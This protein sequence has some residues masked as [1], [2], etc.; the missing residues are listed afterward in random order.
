M[1]EEKKTDDIEKATLDVEK[2]MR[3]NRLLQSMPELTKP[4]E[5][6]VAQTAAFEQSRLFVAA[7]V[8]NHIR[9]LAGKTDEKSMLEA[10]GAS[11]Q[12][13]IELDRCFKGLAKDP[14]AYDRW[15]RGH[16]LADMVSALMTLMD[17]YVLELGK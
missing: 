1:A 15:S 6:T 2:R 14:D 4:E 16:S 8:E 9:P 17:W 12:A 3:G 7:A 11:G 5:M 13:A 10:Q